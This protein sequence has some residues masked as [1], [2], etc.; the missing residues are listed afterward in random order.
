V[1]FKFEGLALG[2]SPQFF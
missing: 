2:S 1:S